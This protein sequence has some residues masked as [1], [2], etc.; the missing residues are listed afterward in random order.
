MPDPN[1]LAL[2]SAAFNKKL[3]GTPDPNAPSM[4]DK[5]K[6]ML[7]PSPQGSPQAM[8][9]PSPSPPPGSSMEALQY[10]VNKAFQNP[11]DPQVAA[12]LQALKNI[13]QR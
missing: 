4:F 8:P 6:A 10:G 11:V 1:Q 2:I 3:G 12:R 5:L 7:S 13:Q 9:S